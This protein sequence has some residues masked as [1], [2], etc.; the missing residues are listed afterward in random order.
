ML[1]TNCR[2]ALQKVTRLKSHVLA[3][4]NPKRNP[5][6]TQ[7]QFGARY[8]PS[9]PTGAPPKDRPATGACPTLPRILLPCSVRVGRILLGTFRLRR[10]YYLRPRKERTTVRR[11]PSSFGSNQNRGGQAGGLQKSELHKPG[12]FGELQGELRDEASDVGFQQQSLLEH[13]P[14]HQQQQ[15]PPDRREKE[16]R[17]HNR[18]QRNRPFTTRGDKHDTRL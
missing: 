6:G 5:S 9:A 3:F 16:Q 7:A 8:S 10:A 12:E 15:A 14:K 17:R 4:S 1:R 2:L 13:A 11:R 18:Q